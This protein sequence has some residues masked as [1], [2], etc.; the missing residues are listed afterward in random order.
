M[1][2]PKINDLMNLFNGLPNLQLLEGPVN[3][4]KR[5][6]LPL[7]WAKKRYP[8]R[9][10]LNGYLSA[11]DMHDLPGDITQFES[12]YRHRSERMARRLSE[13]LG[14]VGQSAQDVPA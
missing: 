11:H 1:P 14:V 2:E 7:D 6:Q 9:A 10:A 8:D 3:V 5:A 12:F 13:M 4:E